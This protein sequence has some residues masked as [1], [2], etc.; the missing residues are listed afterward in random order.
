M[1]HK[2][3]SGYIA[4][5]TKYRLLRLDTAH[6]SLQLFLDQADS[7][8]QIDPDLRK[9]VAET[10]KQRRVNFERLLKAGRL[11]NEAKMLEEA[12]GRK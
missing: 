6:H 11:R 3:L 7:S 5:D 8:Y 9:T 2:K 10:E 12:V 1:T 4:N